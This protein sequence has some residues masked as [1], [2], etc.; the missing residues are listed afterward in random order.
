MTF[1]I[2][3]EQSEPGKLLAIGCDLL[4]EYMLNRKLNYRK[5]DNATERRR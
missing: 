2:L 3:I 1:R 4:R 5:E